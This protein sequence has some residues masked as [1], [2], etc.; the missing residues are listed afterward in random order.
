MIGSLQLA[1]A[2]LL[3]AAGLAKLVAPG[4][5]AAMLR[6]AWRVVPSAVVRA[7][8]AIEMVVALA[9]IALGD[10]AAALA[11]GACY[12]AC[13]AVSV[14][15]MQRRERASCGCFGRADAPVGGVH[16][17][18]NAAA[19]GIAAAAALRPPGRFGGLFEDGALHGVVGV[20]Q[21]ALL[22]YLAFLL[23][24]ALPALTA[25]RRRLMEAR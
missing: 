4:P 16:L 2:L 11:L 22:A 14:R 5:A 3:G 9:V 20:G 18:V 19:F 17:A 21:S 15:L 1:A 25:A 23:L 10:R 13:A 8:A 24:T 7:A 12:L 6:R